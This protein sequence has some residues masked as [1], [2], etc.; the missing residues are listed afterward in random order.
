VSDGAPASP[1]GRSGPRDRAWRQTLIITAAGIGI[2]VVV[3]RLPMSR[4]SLHYA[5]FGAGGKNY[6]E[7]CEPGSPQFAPVDAV[8]SPVTLEV[9][10]AAPCERGRPA[11]VVVRLTAASGKPVGE[12][13]LI[14]VH[15]RKLH[16]LVVSA[17]L[18]DYHHAH[19]QPTD[20]A[21]EFEFTFTPRQTGT[22]RVFA[23]FTPRATGR[24]LYAGAKLDVN[25][26]AGPAVSPVPAAPDDSRVVTLED[27]R[28]ELRSDRDPLRANE[29]ARIV[30]DVMRVDG[31]PLVLE[32][33][34]GAAAHLVAF[35]AACSGFAHLHPAPDEA[36]AD[37]V[38]PGSAGDGPRRRLAFQ[39]RLSEPGFYRLWAQLKIDGRE[40]FVP[41]RVTVEP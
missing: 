16:L 41:F 29:T 10:G 2:F 7:F 24:A 25:E 27:V 20:R 3:Q 31:T 22:Y 35:D 17:S 13:D 33:L 40:R 28:F 26:P 15:T 18:D 1:P 30:L 37:A 34:M 8:R 5:D 38:P 14:E 4:G 23:D 21:G 6:L 32:E 9:L 36:G 39:L 19:P 12:D 11:R